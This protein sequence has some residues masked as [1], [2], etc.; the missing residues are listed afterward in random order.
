MTETGL[1]SKRLEARPRPRGRPIL[2]VDDDPTV[3]NLVSDLLRDAGYDPLPAADGEEALRLIEDTRPVLVL[4]DIQMPNLDGASFARELRMRLRQIPVI[5][6]TG[7]ARPD[8]AADDANA[9]ACL[10]K[11]FDNAALIRL[12]RRFAR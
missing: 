9:V 10:P 3:R 12:V 6:V 2:V 7:V 11:P 1:T 5:V 4:L 8:R